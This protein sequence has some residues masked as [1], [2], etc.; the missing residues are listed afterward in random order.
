[1]FEDDPGIQSINNGN[2]VDMVGLPNEL[3]VAAVALVDNGPLPENLDAN[4]VLPEE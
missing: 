4:N 2:Q 3:P 1:M